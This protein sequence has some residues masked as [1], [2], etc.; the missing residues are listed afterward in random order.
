MPTDAERIRA[1]TAKADALAKTVGAL[2]EKV[3]QLHDSVDVQNVRNAWKVRALGAVLGVALLIVAGVGWGAYRDHQLRVQ[4]LCPLYAIF[5]KSYNP[6]S[7]A[8]KAQG[9]EEYRRTF[10]DIY[11]QYGVLGCGNPEVY[12]FDPAT[13]HTGG[14]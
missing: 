4:V 1:L 10:E 2:G 11:H 3:D 9:I 6:G 14:K 12:S 7:T 5:V 8:A 13:G